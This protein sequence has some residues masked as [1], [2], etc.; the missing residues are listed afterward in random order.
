MFVKLGVQRNVENFC[1]SGH[2]KSLSVILSNIFYIYIL[3]LNLEKSKKSY[4]TFSPHLLFSGCA[5]WLIFYILELSSRSLQYKILWSKLQYIG[6]VIVPITLFILTLYFSGY[7]NWLNIKLNYALLVV[8]FIALI[9][10]F[11]N[12]KHHLF[13]KEMALVSTGNYFLMEIN[14]VRTAI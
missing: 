13:W 2:L 11:T 5:Y 7:Q 6:I 10:V 14:K 8:P 9:F 12:G 3:C 4:M 1:S